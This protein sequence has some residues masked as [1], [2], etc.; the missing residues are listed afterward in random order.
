MFKLHFKRISQS[1]FISLWVSSAYWTVEDR[2]AATRASKCSRKWE[3]PFEQIST[4]LAG[5]LLCTIYIHEIK[6]IYPHGR[7]GIA[8]S[9]QRNTY[10]A[11]KN[12]HNCKG[13]MLWAEKKGWAEILPRG[14]SQF[15]C[16]TMRTQTIVYVLAVSISKLLRGTS[17]CSGVFLL[18]VMRAL[19]LILLFTV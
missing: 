2:P 11:S 15:D 16:K 9:H 8:V 14:R 17:R 13:K 12:K 3:F 4:R 10:D 1:N 6:Y 19:W 5:T 18:D 7:N